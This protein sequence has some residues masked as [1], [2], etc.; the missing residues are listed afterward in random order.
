MDRAAEQQSILGERT[1]LRKILQACGKRNRRQHDQRRKYAFLCR[2]AHIISS[3]L[4][5][6]F[7]L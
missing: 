3:V 6:L 7:S 2:S 1:A 4:Q 5:A